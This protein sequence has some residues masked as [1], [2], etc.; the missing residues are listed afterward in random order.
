MTGILV[1]RSYNMSMSDG[2]PT[3]VS[4][5]RERL[6]KHVEKMCADGAVN[7]APVL[8]LLRMAKTPE[9]AGLVFSALE[10]QDF[11]DPEREDESEPVGR[12][13]WDLTLNAVRA[14]SVLAQQPASSSRASADGSQH[15]INCALSSYARGWLNSAE[16]ELENPE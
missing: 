4:M 12:Y 5:E 2:L 6:I 13:A 15:V 11:I 10:E 9:A 1:Q 3:A 14:W 16:K 8:V 7:R